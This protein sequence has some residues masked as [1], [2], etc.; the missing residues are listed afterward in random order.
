ML[1]SAY[2][3]VSNYLFTNIETLRNSSIT[4][5][6][7]DYVKRN[8]GFSQPD[9][10]EFDD[11]PAEDPSQIAAKKTQEAA[12]QSAAATADFI[13]T[14][15]NYGLFVVWMF[16]C[17]FI[18][19]IVANDLIYYPI[20]VRIF[21]FFFVMTMGYYSN[22]NVP[23]L[24]YFI[25]TYYTVNSLY[26]GYRLYKQPELKGKENYLPTFYAILPI[27]TAD[28]SFLDSWLFPFT[29]LQKGND[30]MDVYY[31]QLS[32][33]TPTYIEKMKNNFPKFAEYE[34]NAEY[35]IKSLFDK[36]KKNLD[37]KDPGSINFP[38]RDIAAEAAEAAAAAKKEG[39]A[40]A[41]TKA[42]PAA[43]PTAPPVAA[44]TGTQPTAPP[45][46]ANTSTQPTAPPGTQPTAPPPAAANAKAPPAAAN[47]KPP[48][49]AANTVQGA[50]V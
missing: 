8:L 22:Y 25:T 23:N 20:H 41:T 46:A 12:Q 7:T 30:K 19:S 26:T 35:D 29:Y 36:Y 16:F 3:G 2:N 48:P 13:M 17:V 37:I 38:N 40:A 49:A 28:K 9:K 31:N 15:I 44:N 27:R 1:S 24:V 5:G 34:G 50:S 43:Q 21:A 10:E 6:V 33:S 42:P 11:P 18:A 39:P 14:I 4:T 45:A 47:T 32:V